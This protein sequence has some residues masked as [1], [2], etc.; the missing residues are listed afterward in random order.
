MFKTKASDIIVLFTILGVAIAIYASNAPLSAPV[1]KSTTP[2][3]PE[4][5]LVVKG[6]QV[7]TVYIYRG[8]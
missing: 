3:T 4:I 2:I 6:N 8:K 5:E 1:V 7:D